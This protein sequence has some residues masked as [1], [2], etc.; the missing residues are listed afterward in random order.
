M[1][2]GGFQFTTTLYHLPS[3]IFSTWFVISTCECALSA[4]KY[5]IIPHIPA[6]ETPVGINLR[7]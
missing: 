1:V 6:V 5:D 3:T 2:V 7:E 4:T